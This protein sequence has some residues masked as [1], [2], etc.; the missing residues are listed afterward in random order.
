MSR[1]GIERVRM[2]KKHTVQNSRAQDMKLIERSSKSLL[3]NVL[4]IEDEI[5]PD[6]PNGGVKPPL[7][8]IADNAG[9]GELMAILKEIQKITRKYKA[10]ED[11]E[12]VKGDWK[13]AAMVID[14]LCLIICGLFTILS[15]IIIL[16]SA[17]HLL[18]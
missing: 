6:N 3:A 15:T 17:P 2:P 12:E 8:L 7:P 18:A 1:P 13:F 11:D 14:R 16:A 4:D 5:R 10:D 9:R